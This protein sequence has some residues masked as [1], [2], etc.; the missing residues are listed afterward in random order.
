MAEKIADGI[1]ASKE[2]ENPF[3]SIHN[4][5]LFVRFDSAGDL[6]IN[7]MPESGM[8]LTGGTITTVSK[9]TVQRLMSAPQRLHLAPKNGAEVTVWIEAGHW[10]AEHA[11]R[12][13]PSR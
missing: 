6:D 7:G 9:T 3:G 2:V 1:T 13:H 11:E 12:P 4:G 5:T 10:V 8:P